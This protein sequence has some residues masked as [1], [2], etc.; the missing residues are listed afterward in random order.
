MHRKPE[1]ISVKYCQ[2]QRH[3]FCSYQW[4]A[5]VVVGVLGVGPG[6]DQAFQL[7]QVA[8]EGGAVD[9]EGELRLLLPDVERNVRLELL[10]PPAILALHP[11]K[12]HTNA[13]G[14]IVH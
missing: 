12:K 11:A 13:S 8:V 14:D 1:L 3:A 2:W 6:P 5:P 7:L 4:S 10:H 9:P